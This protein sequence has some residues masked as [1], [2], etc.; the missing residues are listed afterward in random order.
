MTTRIK[1]RGIYCT[2]F[3][4]LL[5]DGGYSIVQ[6]SQ[7]I[8]E[9]FDLPFNDEPYEISLQE[10][11]DLQG[12]ELTGEPERI[13][14]L[15]TFLQERL[16]D[17]ILMDCGP[18]QDNEGWVTARVELPGA[19]KEALDLVRFSVAPTIM[20]HHRFKIIDPKAL[21]PSEIELTRHPEKKKALE[22]K[23]FLEKILLPIEK[24]GLVTLEHI[25]PSGKSM[26]P[27]EGVLVEARNDAVVFK[28]SFSGGR[29]D[30]LDV[31]I[32]RGDYGLTEVREGSWY[33]RH[34]Y[35]TREGMP[36]GEYYNINTPVELY[37]GGARYVDLEVDV[38]CRAGEE[39][40]LIDREKLALLGKKGCIGSTLE[41]KAMQVA[42]Q[43]LRNL[44]SSTTQAVR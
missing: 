39:A 18:M 3:T 24:A 30:G 17:P 28:R 43:I 9:R 5:L 1:I 20:R 22:E 33:V 15:V 40:S 21:E 7:K 12:I 35:Y 31:P 13:S 38:V 2:A 23:V 4:R 34:S 14:Q 29:Y 32:Q 41:E 6:P 11:D 36:I 42:E 16:V 25:R 19:S 27:R 26:R 8:V 37:P 10:T 44:Q